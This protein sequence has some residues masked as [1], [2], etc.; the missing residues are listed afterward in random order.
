MKFIVVIECRF[1]F[2]VDDYQSVFVETAIYI[3]AISTD[4]NRNVGVE[5]GLR[6]RITPNFMVVERHDVESGIFGSDPKVPVPVFGQFPNPL[7]GQGILLITGQILPEGEGVV[8][9]I[10]D[11]AVHRTD[12]QTSFAVAVSG[13]H[14]IVGQ[15]GRVE[16]VLTEVL[17]G[18]CFFIDDI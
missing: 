8:G 13:I 17:D 10:V 16:Q 14:D 11:S 6:E 9:Q 12:P 15:T 1:T 2:V 5:V 4:Y 3:V 18:L 7:A